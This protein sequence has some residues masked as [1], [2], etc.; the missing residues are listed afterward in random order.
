MSKLVKDFGVFEHVKIVEP[1]VKMVIWEGAFADIPA[2][3]RYHI[4]TNIEYSDGVAEI[5]VG[6]KAEDSGKKF[7]F[8]VGTSR[9]TGFVKLTMKE[10]ILIAKVS[11]TGN[12][13]GVCCGGWIGDFWIDLDSAVDA[14]TFEKKNNIPENIMNVWK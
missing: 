1:S 11:D 3:Y 13:F 4:V 7:W 9:D 8:C 14:E 12:W 10:A 2:E 5:T 6:D